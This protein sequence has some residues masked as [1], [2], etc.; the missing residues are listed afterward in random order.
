MFLSHFQGQNR[1][2]TGKYY[3]LV[4]QTDS[5]EVVIIVSRD[6]PSRWFFPFWKIWFRFQFL[7]SLIAK[8]WHGLV[9]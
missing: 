2:V 3:F 6:D 9:E 8:I 1:A 4:Y 7:V 5:C